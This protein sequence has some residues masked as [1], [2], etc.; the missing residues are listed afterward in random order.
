MNLHVPALANDVTEQPAVI[1]LIS[2]CT[3]AF[4]FVKP[5]V[6]QKVTIRKRFIFDDF[7]IFRNDVIITL[8]KPFRDS[9]KQECSG[10]RR[11]SGIQVSVKISV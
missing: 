11:Q 9:L 3:P 5:C 7:Q 6:S 4:F 1:S 8:A 2:N 10:A